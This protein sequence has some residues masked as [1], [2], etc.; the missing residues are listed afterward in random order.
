MNLLPPEGRLGCGLG[1][2]VLLGLLTMLVPQTGLFLTGFNLGG[3]FAAIIL[4]LLELIIHIS[5]KWITMSVLVVLGTLFAGL[6]L[7]FQK[8]ITIIS[9]GAIGGALALS[10]VDYFVEKARMAHYFW[11]RLMV[12]ESSE[13]CWYSWLVMGLW[14]SLA[15]MGVLVQWKL[16]AQ[17][18]DH[19]IGMTIF[20]LFVK[21][22]KI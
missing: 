11:E 2:G 1:A 16:T 7:C 8:A 6:G 4:I 19:T 17:D 3:A 9:T 18:I 15:A 10:S 21:L 13:L 12:D 20:C 5:T 22:T 14:P